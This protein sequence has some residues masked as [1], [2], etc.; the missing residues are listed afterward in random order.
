MSEANRTQRAV[1][2]QILLKLGDLQQ[3][4]YHHHWDG[5]IENRG[6][7]RSGW[8][9]VLVIKDISQVLDK[10]LPETTRSLWTTWDE[11]SGELNTS[12]DAEK[13]IITAIDTVRGDTLELLRKLD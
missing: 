2:I 5:D 13:A 10:P 8:T 11:R 3:L 4:V 9:I 6:N 12:R 1:A 7:L